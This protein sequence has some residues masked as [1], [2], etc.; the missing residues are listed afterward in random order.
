MNP[1]YTNGMPGRDWDIINTTLDSF[2]ID[3]IEQDILKLLTYFKT[4]N[5]TSIDSWLFKAGGFIMLGDDSVNEFLTF[6]DK[7]KNSG[8]WILRVTASFVAIVKRTA[9]NSMLA[10]FGSQGEKEILANNL[11]EGNIRPAQNQRERDVLLAMID[12][13]P[14][15]FD[16]STEGLDEFLGVQNNVSNNAKCNLVLTSFDEAKKL[17]VIKAV[18]DVMNCSLGEAKDYVVNTPTTLLFAIP[19]DIAEQASRKIEASGGKTNLTR[20]ESK[21]GVG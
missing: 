12:I 21:V 10:A 1:K 2:V 15:Y 3:E 11:K 5:E 7:M 17:S 6:F 16:L 9:L 13:M 8:S 4:H 19:R 20:D 18:K 14:L